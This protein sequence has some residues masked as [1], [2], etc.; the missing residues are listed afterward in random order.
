[1]R[2]IKEYLSD[3][4]KL[5]KWQIIGGLFLIVVLAGMFGWLYEVIFYYFN[6]GM[7]QVYMRGGNFL[8]WINI[9]AT[10]SVM[11]I[12]LSYKYR[13]NPLTVFL[14]AFIS[15]GLLEYFSGWVIYE[16]FGG[17]R[18]W[19]YNTE[20]LNFGN[21]GGFVCLRSVGFFGL[22]S[23]ILMYIMVPFCI[24]LSR[25]LNKKVFLT[26]SIILF[27]LFMFDELYNLIIA[28]VFSLPRATDVYK[29]IG[30]PYMKYYRY[31]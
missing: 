2:T 6:S 25:K 1:M 21:I 18:L 22:S 14:I 17:L 5:E 3:D 7:K 4:F 9:Y 10:G 26:I 23:L 12:L 27:S 19:D 30:I 24:F 11:I 31:K 28:R 13:K 20:I 8:P 16:F 15:T 29:N